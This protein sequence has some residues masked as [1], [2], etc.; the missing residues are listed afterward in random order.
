MLK[1]SGTLLVGS[2]GYIGSNCNMS[3]TDKMD[4]E[5]GHDFLNQ[6]IGPYDCIVFLAARLDPTKAAYEYNEGLYSRLDAW[7][8]MRP[9]THVIYASSA[10]VYGESSVVN[11][12]GDYPRP[13]SLYGESKLSGEF[14]VRE[15]DRH[16]VLRFGNVYG[17]LNGQEG[18]GATELFQ[19][20]VKTIYGDGE[21]VRDF[22]PV[23]KI[24]QVIRMARKYPKYWQGVFN[25]SLS[26]PKTVNQW[27][28]EH[29]HGDPDHVAARRGDIRISLLDNTKMRQRLI[30]CK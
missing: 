21:Q 8:K 6:N 17:K 30:L 19:M 5:S 22:V 27:Y 18:H 26:K 11:R 23:S 13:I 24:W 2:D 20:G 12:E 1:N 16:T 28:A 10:A 9:N 3:D 15:Y 7:L 29:G 25:V 4:I 14:R